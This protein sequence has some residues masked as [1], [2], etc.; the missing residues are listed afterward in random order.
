MALTRTATTLVPPYLVKVIGDIV[1][2]LVIDASLAVEVFSLP[3][4][5]SYDTRH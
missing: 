5:W 3:T 2:K 4:Q 1:L